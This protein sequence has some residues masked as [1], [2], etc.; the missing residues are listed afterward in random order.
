MRMPISL[1]LE[2]TEYCFKIV[3]MQLINNEINGFNFHFIDY[4]LDEN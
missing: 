1:Y 4:Y 3:Q 2:N